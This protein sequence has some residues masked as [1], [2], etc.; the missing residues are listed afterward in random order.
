MLIEQQGCSVKH[1]KKKKLGDARIK[2]T[3]V[4]YVGMHCEMVFN[5]TVILFFPQD[6]L[7][8]CTR[9]TVLTEWVAI[10]YF[11]L[12]SSFSVW[13]HSLLTHTIQTCTE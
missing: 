12:S 8:Q 7:I 2:L 3:Q 11:F 4:L 9:W 13:P 1:S 10:Q 5:Y 6:Y